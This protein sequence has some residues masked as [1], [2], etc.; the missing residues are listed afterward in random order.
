MK[1]YRPVPLLSEFSKIFERLIYKAESTFFDNNLISSNQSGFK[2]GE[3]C[4]N[5]LIAI[6]GFDNGL[7]GRSV[8]LAISK[9]F[10]KVWHERL[11]Y[12]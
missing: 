10:D 2:P 12:E 7:E 4:I 6:E 5:Q 8:F 9:A 3:S 1:N 11:I